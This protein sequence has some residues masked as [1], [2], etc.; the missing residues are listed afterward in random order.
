[1]GETLRQGIK[2]HLGELKTGLGSKEY[3]K[4]FRWNQDQ[5]KSL[6]REDSLSLFREAA[7]EL[8]EHYPDVTITIPK[9]EEISEP[10]R[11]RLSWNMVSSARALSWNEIS[12]GIV[13]DMDLNPYYLRLY[14]GKNEIETF[15]PENLGSKYKQTLEDKV[16]EATLNLRVI[17]ILDKRDPFKTKTRTVLFPLS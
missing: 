16:L 15:I 14:W 12:F 5:I 4:R 6:Q 7:A 10:V 3:Q 8:S 2:R 11:L 9:P 13:P 1:M 17:S